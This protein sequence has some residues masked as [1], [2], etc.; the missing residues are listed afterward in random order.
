MKKKFP[1]PK[2]NYEKGCVDNGT[3]IS[4]QHVDKE[5]F[6]KD[7]MRMELNDEIPKGCPTASCPIIDHSN[8]EKY[9]SKCDWEL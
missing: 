9:C 5:E 4:I 7:A 1:Q 8:G 6:E 2:P 3:G